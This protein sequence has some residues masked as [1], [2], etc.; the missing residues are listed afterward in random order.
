MET[1]LPTYLNW[2]GKLTDQNPS[3]K[4]LVRYTPSA[5]DACA[6][7]ID[8]RTFDHPFVVDHKTYWCESNSEAEAH[9]VA[10]YVNSNFANNKIKE[11]QSR[12]LSGRETSTSS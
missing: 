8:R 1:S 2:Q 6:V 5:T 10:A 12:G 7:V 9:F 11:F 3:A 4:F